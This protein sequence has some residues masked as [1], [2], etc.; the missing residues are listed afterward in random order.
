MTIALDIVLAVLTVSLAVW[1]IFGRDPLDAVLGFI[2]MGVTI[3]LIWV[4]LASIDVA[5]T[6]AAIGSGATG[7]LLLG[8][9]TLRHPDVTG[10]ADYTAG[11]VTR[12]LIAV[13]CCIVAVAVA[14]AVLTLPNPAPSLATE[15]VSNMARLDLGNPVA[16]VLLGYRA[17][18]TFLEAVVLVLAL[19]GVWS[20]TPDPAWGG[21]GG[22]WNTDTHQTSLVFLAR[23]L[24]PVGL[25]VGVHLAWTGAVAPGGAFQGGTVLA[26]MWMLPMMA[27]LTRPPSVTAGWARASVVVG[28][29]VFLIAGLAGVWSADGF[30]AYPPGMEKPVILAIEAALTLSIA[31]TLAL[32]IAGPATHPPS[33]IQA[34]LQ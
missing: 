23:V 11:F 24:P 31:V 8:A 16:A 15:A 9:A 32:I 10:T 29:A 18:D 22:R 26:A 13:L 28:P 20:L 19:V 17:L 5:L 2:G 27:G 34:S 14:A 1:T 33:A 25:L 6:E 21:P 30:L 4:R 3:T 7:V 12:W